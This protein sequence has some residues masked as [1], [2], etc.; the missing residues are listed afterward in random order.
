MIFIF[1]L[2]AKAGL[3]IF[4][5]NVI[6]GILNT[7]FLFAEEIETALTLLSERTGNPLGFDSWREN[8]KL[9]PAFMLR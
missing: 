9:T 6:Y 2:S 5:L 7:T 8:R 4:Y 3:I 1:L